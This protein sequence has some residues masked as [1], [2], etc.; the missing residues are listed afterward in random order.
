[1]SG[2]QVPPSHPAA[3]PLPHFPPCTS[4]YIFFA[5]WPPFSFPSRPLRARTHLGSGSGTGYY[6]TRARSVR[7]SFRNAGHATRIQLEDALVQEGIRIIQLAAIVPEF[8]EWNGGYGDADDATGY[9]RC[10]GMSKGRRGWTLREQE[11]RG[12]IGKAHRWNGS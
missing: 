12:R 3:A 7:I 10:V 6:V 2:S 9:S 8:R 5:W 11:S 4:F 1:M